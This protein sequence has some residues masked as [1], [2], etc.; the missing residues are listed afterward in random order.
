M[1]L[2]AAPINLQGSGYDFPSGTVQL[3]WPSSSSAAGDALSY[4]LRYNIY[5]GSTGA[6]V[7]KTSD[8]SSGS[9]PNSFLDLSVSPAVLPASFVVT[10]VNNIGDESLHS[11][12]LVLGLFSYF[13]FFL[14]S[15]SLF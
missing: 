5:D 12:L 2:P 3:F 10:T 14:S 8:G 9:P 11:P 6:F 7:G 4:V 15:H 1:P 13:L